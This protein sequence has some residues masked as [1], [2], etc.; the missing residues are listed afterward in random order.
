M[1]NILYVNADAQVHRSAKVDYEKP[2]LFSDLPSKID[3]NIVTLENF[4]DLPSGR[5]VNI[6]LGSYFNLQGVIISKSDA[7]DADIKSIVIKSINRRGA[8][9]TFTRIH[10]K[11]GSF[12]YLGRMFSSNHSDAFEITFKNDQYIL[13]KRKTLDIINE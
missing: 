12:S 8:T 13:T 6:P 3:L 7:G 10:N 2:E 9:F 11:D 5:Q 4:L 1:L